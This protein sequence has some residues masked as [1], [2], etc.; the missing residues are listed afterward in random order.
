MLERAIALLTH[1]RI[2]CHVGAFWYSPTI[3]HS[4]TESDRLTVRL[5]DRSISLLQN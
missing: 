3:C 1:F 2:R 4:P 5:S